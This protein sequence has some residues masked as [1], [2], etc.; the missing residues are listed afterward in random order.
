MYWILREGTERPIYSTRLDPE[1]TGSSGFLWIIPNPSKASFHQRIPSIR[2]LFQPKINKSESARVKFEIPPD[3]VRISFGHVGD[4][5]G[6]AMEGGICGDLHLPKATSLSPFESIF[7]YPTSQLRHHTSVSKCISYTGTSVRSP[8]Y[9]L[10]GMLRTGDREKRFRWQRD[11]KFKVRD[12]KLILYWDIFVNVY[13]MVRSLNIS[14][15]Y[16]VVFLSGRL[17]VL[18]INMRG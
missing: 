16:K 4:G 18:R 14:L 9:T 10:G 1:H 17:Y 13:Y 12:V 2:S 11:Q 15:S 5:Y 6:I 3:A 8:E 7:G